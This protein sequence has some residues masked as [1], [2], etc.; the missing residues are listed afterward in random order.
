MTSFNVLKGKGKKSTSKHYEVPEGALLQRVHLKPPF[1]FLI[2][3]KL[4][5]YSI[6]FS[7]KN[8][9]F[10]FKKSIFSLQKKAGHFLTL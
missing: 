5:L 6:K 4:L 3:Q 8:L 10:F 9:H 7:R 1:V 2:E